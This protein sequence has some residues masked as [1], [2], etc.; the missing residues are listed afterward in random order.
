MPKRKLGERET[1]K[2]LGFPKPPPGEVRKLN[3]AKGLACPQVS[4]HGRFRSMSGSIY[5][6]KPMKCGR[7][8]V[9]IQGYDYHLAALICRAIHGPAPSKMHIAQHLNLDPSNN[10][11][12]N[13]AWMTKKESAQHVRKANKNRKSNARRISKPIRGRR[14]MGKTEGCKETPWVKYELGATEAAKKL[15]LDKKSISKCCGGTLKTTGGYEFEYDL[16]MNLLLPEEQF[17]EVVFGDG[18]YDVPLKLLDDL[19]NSNH[20]L[21]IPEISNKGRWMDTQGVIKTPGSHP[22][23]Y[24]YIM[25][26][27]VNFALHGL[28]CRAFHGPPLIDTDTP[29][30]INRDTT[31]NHADNLRWATNSERATDRD[32]GCESNKCEKGTKKWKPCDTQIPKQHEEVWYDVVEMD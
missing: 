7:V 17:R 28:V 6:P 3:L 16:S 1:E 32:A 13:L 19:K 12:A 18:Q 22:S 31:N 5:I 23:G 25:I 21:Q 30:H 8:K 11:N 14:K 2:W 15:G 9:N 26:M 29:N 4:S 20:S 24:S 10:H 27:G